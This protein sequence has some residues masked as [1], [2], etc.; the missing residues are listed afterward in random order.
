[1]RKKKSK[2]IN[3]HLQNFWDQK[4][5]EKRKCSSWNNNV[6]LEFFLN[7]KSVFFKKWLVFLSTSSVYKQCVIFWNC[8]NSSLCTFAVSISTNFQKFVRTICYKIS[9]YRYVA[10]NS[11]SRSLAH[12]GIFRHFIM[13]KFKGYL[14]SPFGEKLIFA[15]VAWSTVGNYTVSTVN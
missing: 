11:T 10:N 12:P 8:W 3:I 4:G 15:I 2:F 13:V 6:P 1:M 14:Q 5:S 7:L 9:S